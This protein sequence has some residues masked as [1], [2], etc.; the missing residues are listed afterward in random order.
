MSEYKA[1]KLKAITTD[2]ASQKA[3]VILDGTSGLVRAGAYGHDGELQL[4]PQNI[5]DGTAA[6]GGGNASVIGSDHATIH[7]RASNA[8]VRIGGGDASPGALGGT[9]P[10]QDG[11]VTLRNAANESV[12]VL[13]AKTSD[14]WI[15]GADS[16]HAPLH[17]DA[18]N[19]ALRIGGGAAPSGPFLGGRDGVFT[20][21]DSSGTEHVHLDATGSLALKDA[22]H[23]T[24][25]LEATGGKVHIYDSAGKSQIYLHGESGN[26]ELKTGHLQLDKGDVIVKGGGNIHVRDDGD[27]TVGGSDCAEEFDVLESETSEPGTVVVIDQGGALR[28]S[29]EAYDRRVAG[30]LSG[31]GAFKPGLVLG[32]NQPGPHRLPVALVGKVYCKVDAQHSAIDVGDLLTTSP[33]PGHALKATDQTRAFGAVIGKAMRP[34]NTGQGLIPILIALQ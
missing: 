11:K 1:T 17:F 31:A 33:T 5:V 25:S 12:I 34:L 14:V 28:S 19:G 20:L 4:I 13:D 9:H 6:L 3:T 10:G 16:T 32:R 2:D 8:H 26:I 15:G 30:V 18:A 21:Q 7:M 22:L 27:I 29:T 24:I 23:T